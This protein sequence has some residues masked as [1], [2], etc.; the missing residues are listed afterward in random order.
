VVGGD[1]W[2][3]VACMDVV[4]D[5]V[6]CKSSLAEV[7]GDVILR[8]RPLKVGAEEPV[9]IPHEFNCDH[10]SEKLFKSGS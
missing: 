2:C 5:K 6:R 7:D 4:F 8:A 1:V 9:N 10:S 3:N